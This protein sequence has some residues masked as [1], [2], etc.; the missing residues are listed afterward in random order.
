MSILEEQKVY[1]DKNYLVQPEPNTTSDNGIRFTAEAIFATSQF[2][3]LAPHRRE[4]MQ[5]IEACQLEPGLLFRAPDRKDKQE[6]PDDYYAACA[7]AHFLDPKLAIAIYNYG[8]KHWF[9]FNNEGKW[10]KSQFFAWLQPAL[11]AHMR[12]CAGEKLYIWHQLMVCLGLYLCTRS[13]DQDG[14]VLQWFVVRAVKG[15]YWLIDKMIS[16]WSKKLKQF[17]SGGIGE[18]LGRYYHPAH[19]EHPN[20]KYL[21]GVFD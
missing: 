12:H 4:L 9:I 7:V 10:N 17:A 8:K 11:R 14:W 6:G 5:A 19:F 13:D 15:R 1:I 16:Y 21:M 3:S 20:S 2:P 18:V